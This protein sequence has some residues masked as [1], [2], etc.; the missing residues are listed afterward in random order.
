VP[1][2]ICEECGKPTEQK[3]PKQTLCPNCRPTVYRRRATECER[4]RRADLGEAYR[5]YDRQVKSDP[6]TRKK[7]ALYARDYYNKMKDNPEF[8]AKVKATQP[9]RDK[10]FHNNH[11]FGG[12]WFKVYIR[13]S[14]KCQTCGSTKYLLVHHKDGRG[15]GCVREEKNNDMSNLILLCSSC[16]AKIHGLGVK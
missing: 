1:T 11:E 16:H 7:R 9:T 5:A 6:E 10:D 8:K 13:D 15:K 2:I 3:R 12:N 14:G 4:K